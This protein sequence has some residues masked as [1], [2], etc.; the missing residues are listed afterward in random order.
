[1]EARKSLRDLTESP[2]LQRFSALVNASLIYSTVRLADNSRNRDFALSDRP[3][4]GQ[5]PYVVNAGLFTKTTKATC[6]CR[7]STT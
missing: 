1:V 3:L 6:K 5:S 4:Q 7:R 2:I